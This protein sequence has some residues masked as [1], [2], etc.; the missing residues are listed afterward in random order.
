MSPGIIGLI[1]FVCVFGGAL[2]GM[3]LRTFLPGASFE[4]GVEGRRKAGDGVDRDARRTGPGIADRIREEFL[5]GGK[6]SV[7][8]VGGPDRP[9][10][11]HARAVWPGDASSSACSEARLRRAHGTALSDKDSSRREDLGSARGTAAIEGLE[12]RIRAL[13]PQN[14]VQRALQTRALE[15]TD[16]VA[17]ARWMGIEA[18]ENVIPLGLPDGTR[19][20][21]G[22][23]VRE[24]R[25]VRSA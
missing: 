14:E 25:A 2:A 15:I 20:L 8:P 9:A 3:L 4:R 11:S 19:V 13:T 7:S 21:A 23:D 5:R 22:R 10:R 6:R 24:L 1:V 16:S 18:Q 17:Q 12:Q